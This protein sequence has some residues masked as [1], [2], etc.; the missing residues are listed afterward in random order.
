MT[1]ILIT[2]NNNIV[3]GD[4]PKRPRGR[5]RKY[6]TD[7]ER[8]EANRK[9]HRKCMENEKSREI[10][11]ARYKV[12]TEKNKEEIAKRRKIVRDRKK[13]EKEKERLIIL[14]HVRK[15]LK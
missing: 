5:P 11:N 7:E 12:W 10:R 1:T 4:K 15:A 3:K 2:E 8:A 9:A 6:H 13:A 14:E